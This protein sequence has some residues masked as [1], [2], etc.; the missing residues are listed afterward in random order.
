[1]PPIN[2][3]K[4]WTASSLT[5]S[6]MTPTQL[7]SQASVGIGSPANAL[8]SILA[9][10]FPGQNL[11]GLLSTADQ[12]GQM[13]NRGGAANP[14]QILAQAYSD[15]LAAKNNAMNALNLGQQLNTFNQSQVNYSN[16]PLAKGNAF[17]MGQA[18]LP[19]YAK[20]AQAAALSPT[21]APQINQS[22]NS[23]QNTNWSPWGN[24]TSGWTSPI[25][26]PQNDQSFT[27]IGR[28]IMNAGV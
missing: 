14:A 26:R 6:L 21:Y 2:L 1:M 12:S 19:L 9:S 5:P 4:A 10:I 11:G 18:N 16:D 17:L 15:N 22:M 28:S 23:A 3:T 25:A 13:Q 20:V 27:A 8:Q 24:A 7:P